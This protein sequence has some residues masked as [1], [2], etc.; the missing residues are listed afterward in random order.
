ML[1]QKLY[2]NRYFLNEGS[3]SSEREGLLI[4]LDESGFWK[5][6]YMRRLFK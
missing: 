2:E 4:S 1:Y 6:E 5:H 3:E